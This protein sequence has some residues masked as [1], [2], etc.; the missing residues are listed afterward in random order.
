MPEQKL[1]LFFLLITYLTKAN[2]IERAIAKEKAKADAL[3]RQLA[4]LTFAATKPGSPIQMRE[5]ESQE[6][7]NEQSLEDIFNKITIDIV[8]NFEE[9]LKDSID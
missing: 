1:N 8:D 6:T 9:E 5:E 7:E 4:D 3:M 2:L